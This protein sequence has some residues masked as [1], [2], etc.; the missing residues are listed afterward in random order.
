[1]NSPDRFVT[2]ASALAAVV[3]AFILIGERYG[4]IKVPANPAPPPARTATGIRV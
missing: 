4:W 3:L 1:M 2:I